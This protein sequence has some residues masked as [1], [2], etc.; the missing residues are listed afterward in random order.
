MNTLLGLGRILATLL[1]LMTLACASAFA[2]EGE[3][4]DAG[5]ADGDEVVLEDGEPMPEEWLY[6]TTGEPVE[7]DAVVIELEDGSVVM[8][9]GAEGEMGITAMP[10]MST[11]GAAGGVSVNAP[12]FVDAAGIAEVQLDGGPAVA[13]VVSTDFDAPVAPIASPEL[14][15]G[16]ATGVRMHGGHLVSSEAAT[17]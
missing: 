16:S 13:G 8:V 3:A 5:A 17:Q 4:G 11:T 15:A 1:A 6:M 10:L 2:D 12:D 9:D 7:G 14:P